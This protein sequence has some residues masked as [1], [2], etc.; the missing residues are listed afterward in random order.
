MLGPMG[1]GGADFEQARATLEDYLAR[2]GLKHT[3]QRDAILAAFLTQKGHMTSEQ[4]HE[5]VRQKQPEIGAATIYRTL[6]LL[7]EAGIANSIQFRDGVT[8]YERQ[9]AH[10]DHLICQSCGEILEFES[11]L[12]EREQIRVAQE[13]GYRLLRHRHHL[14]GICARCQAHNAPEK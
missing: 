13:R 8:L 14:F 6:K 7:C 2:N 11:E 3:R 4:V 5:R 1:S 12:I 9:V 10:H